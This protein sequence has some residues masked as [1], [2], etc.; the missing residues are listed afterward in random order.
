[1]ADARSIAS[2]VRAET[3]GARRVLTTDQAAAIIA[4][5]ALAL[6]ILIRAGFRG[7]LGD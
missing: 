5:G 1:M 4:L 3:T 2:A 6:L 7:A